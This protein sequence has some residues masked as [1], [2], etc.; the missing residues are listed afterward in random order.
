FRYDDELKTYIMD[1]I[2]AFL[3]TQTD[4]ANG[5][6]KREMLDKYQLSHFLYSSTNQN[7]SN[8]HNSI[9]N[10]SYFGKFSNYFPFEDLFLP[11]FNFIAGNNIYDVLFSKKFPHGF[12]GFFFKYVY[13]QKNTQDL[14][15]NHGLLYLE[16]LKKCKTE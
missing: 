8:Q 7:L 13:R 6:V 3:E 11:V 2:Y 1:H 4:P 16:L 10:V 5:Q 15:E 14:L 12:F 9:R